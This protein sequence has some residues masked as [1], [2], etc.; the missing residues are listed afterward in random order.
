MFNPGDKVNL[1]EKNASRRLKP[2]PMI[3]VSDVR[4]EIR[5][6]SDGKGKVRGENE[7][8]TFAHFANLD[9][10]KMLFPDLEGNRCFS[11][12]GP[13]YEITAR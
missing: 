4:S 1:L 12:R 6:R 8:T 11:Q 13:T 3:V 7:E 5:L 2:I 9:G 10:W